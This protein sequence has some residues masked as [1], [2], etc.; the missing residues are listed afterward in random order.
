MSAFSKLMGATFAVSLAKPFS[1]WKAFEYGLID[2]KGKIIRKP[3]NSPERFALGGIKD[4]IRKIKRLLLKVVPDSRMLGMLIA[5]YL[6]KRESEQT[7]AEK[8]IQEILDKN[9]TESDLNDMINHL[10][11]IL[12]MNMR[13]LTIS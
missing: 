6:L 13:N 3:E 5:A 11:V 4:L 12:N 1:D 7:A 9:M 2:D 8:Q 10:K